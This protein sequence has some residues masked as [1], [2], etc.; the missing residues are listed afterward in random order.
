MSVVQASDLGRPLEGALWMMGAGLSFVGVNG[1]VRYLGTEL[2]AAQSAFIR[3][4]FGLMFLL[5][6]LWAMRGMQF[7]PGVGRMFLGRGALHVVAVI[8][9]FYAMARVPVA[10][11]AA[12]AFLGPVMVLVIGGLLL[13]EG[14]GAR[15]IAAVV[16]AVAGGLIVLRPGVR[17]LSLGHL[18]QLGATVFFSM[19]YIIAKRLSREAPA[20]VIV[21]VLSVTV[22]LGLLPLAMMQWQP[23][24]LEQVCWLACVAGL[25][26][27]GH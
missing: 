10:E 20:S 12:I 6:A 23:V 13:G 2:P 19:S 17:E 16:V 5:P 27:L 1:I 4:G 3:F 25:A 8:L 7:R 22:T 21:G 11:M 26:T 18:S 24:W 9:W 14:L 15:R